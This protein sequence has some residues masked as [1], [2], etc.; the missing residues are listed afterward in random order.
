MRFLSA[1]AII[2]ISLWGAAATAQTFPEPRNTAVNDYADMLPD[3][4]EARIT[5]V[6]D[7]LSADTGAEATIVT[8]SSVQFYA[9]NLT[10]TQYATALFNAWGIGDA[11]DG[12]GVLLLVFR[13][14]RQLRVELGAGYD[15]AA[16]MRARTV[17]SETIVPL[18]VK[19]DFVGGIE[20]GATE[21]AD[22]VVRN[23]N[24]AP[25]PAVTDETDSKSNIL[26]Y[27]LGGIGAA[28]AAIFGLN[29]KAAAKLA[30]TPCSSCGTKGQL[31]KDRETLV[32]ATETTDGKG[33]TRITCG[34]CGHVTRE[35]Y[36]ISKKRVEKDTFKGGKSKGDGATGKW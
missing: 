12:D 20:A 22:Q 21:I 28:A 35:T 34:S 2:A 4:A 8:L 36:T 18:F 30:A 9:Q 31:S 6:L 25:T 32:E 29:R 5:Q 15:D 17:V 13:D 26:W 11:E 23:G 7:D 33:E 3:D 10:V 24:A 16:Q 27:I 19:D 14:D 1:T